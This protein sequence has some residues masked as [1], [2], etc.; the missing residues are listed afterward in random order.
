MK[1][2]MD[3]TCNWYNKYHC[4]SNCS[5]IIPTIFGTLHTAITSR[6][7]QPYNLV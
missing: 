4:N 6:D 1:K 7:M 2:Q 3:I 5:S